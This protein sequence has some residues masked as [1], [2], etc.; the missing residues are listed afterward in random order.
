MLEALPVNVLVLDPASAKITFANGPSVTTLNALRE[1]LPPGV[2]PDAMVGSSMDVFHKNPAHQR[3][4]VSDPSRLPW[5]TKI[6]L[7]PRTLDLHVSA[8]RDLDGHYVAAVLSWADV[9]T[10][11]DSISRFDQSIQSAFAEAAQ[12]TEAMRGAARAVDDATRET[13]S[14]AS[15]ASAGATS[16]SGN[17]QAVAAAVEEM[18]VANREVSRQMN[19]TSRAAQQAVAEV[20]HA[21]ESV[22]ALSQISRKIGEVVNMITAIA[23]QTNL[24]AL[25]ATIEAARAGAAG[26]GFAVVAAEV[27]ELANQT[28]RATAEI[29]GHITQV[30]S[31]TAATSG[32]VGRIAEIIVTVNQSATT[33][34]VAAEQQGATVA[35]IGRSVRSASEQTVAVGQNIDAVAVS[36]ANSSGSARTALDATARLETE[37]EA[38]TG[39]VQLF[40]GEVKKI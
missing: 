30:Q 9:T 12:A 20:G 18:T 26:R 24:L 36:A 8:V 22:D 11:A 13:S 6:K 25:N 4:I 5:R 38:I 16:T 29:S 1:H 40:M 15:S 35:E 31:A 2:D 3:A 10:L 33:V 28:A 17:V 23:E 7:G 37:L 34:A 39:A 32:A 21:R 14:A 19:E 27:K